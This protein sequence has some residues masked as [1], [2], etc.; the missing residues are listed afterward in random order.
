MN[1]ILK[2]NQSQITHAST[3]IPT[4]TLSSPQKTFLDEKSIN[5]PK[6]KVKKIMIFLL[7]KSLFLF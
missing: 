6:S 4:K 7:Y 3:V 2:L 1:E 5:Q